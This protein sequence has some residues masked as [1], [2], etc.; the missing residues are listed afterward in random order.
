[1]ENTSFMDSDI[2]NLTLHYT[3][4]LNNSNSSNFTV[5]NVSRAL[6]RSRRPEMC[7]LDQESWRLRFAF[8]V[9]LSLPVEILG[10]LGNLLALIVLFKQ[11]PTTTTTVLLQCLAVADIFVLVFSMMFR[12]LRTLHECFIPR[13]PY[14][15][16]FQ[17]MMQYVFPFV[18]IARLCSTWLTV[19]LTVDRYIAVCK[20]LH[21]QRL[22]TLSRVAKELLV[23][24]LFAVGYNIVR[25]FE[26]DYRMKPTSLAR[27]ARYTIFYKMISFGLVYYVI[28]ICLLA[29]LNILLVRS[30]RKAE[31]S[32]DQ[33]RAPTKDSAVMKRDITIVVAAVVFIF[34]ACNIPAMMSHI[35]YSIE[36]AYKSTKGQ[37]EPVR[38]H[39][40]RV[41]NFL[42]ILNSAVNFVIY[43]LFSRN[44]RKTFQRLFCRR[45]Q[46]VRRVS[47]GSSA[48]SGSTY[49]SLNSAKVQHH[50]GD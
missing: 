21:A 5:D 33:L 11:K 26:I 37:L 42:I 32:R 16:H 1:M 8:S 48:K 49:F 38:R 4:M 47:Q 28:P 22:C 17:V 44:F 19:L 46:H 15:T 12:S 7:N 31:E 29:T 39:F 27:N 34:L 25:F 20:P 41:S 23:L 2:G 40:A 24:V 50:N 35:F 3:G 30:L 43:C 6:T 10:I 45:F 9:V 18:Y 14:W 36:T 13:G